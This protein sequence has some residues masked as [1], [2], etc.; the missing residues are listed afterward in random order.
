MMTGVVR[1][2]VVYLFMFW[3][4]VCHTQRLRGWRFGVALRNVY[5]Y[6]MRVTYVY[7]SYHILFLDVYTSCVESICIVPQRVHIH[8]Y[9]Y[10]TYILYMYVCVHMCTYVYTYIHMCIICIIYMYIIYM[11]LH[12]CM[13]VYTLRCWRVWCGW[14]WC[15]SY[16]AYYIL[17]HA[18]MS[19]GICTYACMDIYTGIYM[20][21]YLYI[22]IN[23]MY[24]MYCVLSTWTSIHVCIYS[25]ICIRVYTYPYTHEYVSVRIHTCVYIHVCVYLHT[26]LLHVYI[27]YTW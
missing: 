7:I 10:T 12:I 20:N 2:C 21:T 18:F 27:F 13:Y 3:H 5:A 8:T 9:V 24:I 15:I 19:V 17:E 4:I 23:M 11:H 25:H 14:R 1:L 16:I 26:Y 22:C 6:C